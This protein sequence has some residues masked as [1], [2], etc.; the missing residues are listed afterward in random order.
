M[1]YMNKSLDEAVNQ[2]NISKEKIEKLVANG[3]LSGGY[4]PHFGNGEFVVYLPV[5]A[6]DDFHYEVAVQRR[7]NES[8]N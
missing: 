5:T 8:L 6:I 1:F 2:L 7:K 3:T 4:D